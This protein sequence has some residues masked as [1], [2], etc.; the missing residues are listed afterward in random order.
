MIVNFE[1]TAVFHYNGQWNQ[2]HQKTSNLKLNEGSSLKI[3]ETWIN[4][5]MMYK[6]IYVSKSADQ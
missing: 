5:D 1:T 4:V 6:L 3:Y 2:W